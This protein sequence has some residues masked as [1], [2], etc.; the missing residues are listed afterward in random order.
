MKEG[1][2]FRNA[3]IRHYILCFIFLTLPGYSFSS[4]PTTSPEVVLSEVLYHSPLS[5]LP[6]GGERGEFIEIYNPSCSVIDLA[7]YR[8]Q[9]NNGN[10]DAYILS[11]EIAPGQYKT[12]TNDRN[13]FVKLFGR[14]PDMDN[15]SVKLG[16]SGDFVA[17]YHN[18][19]SVDLVS[20]EKAKPGWDLTAKN[21]SLIR[22]SITGSTIPTDWVVYSG[23]NIAY[24]TP[25]TGNLP[26][27]HCD[28]ATEEE[29]LHLE[30]SNVNKTIWINNE[31]KFSFT[32]T[33]TTSK[34][35]VISAKIHCENINPEECS[36]PSVIASALSQPNV[37]T[38]VN[39]DYPHGIKAKPG[40]YKF[41]IVARTRSGEEIQEEQLITLSEDYYSN[42]K[43]KTGTE[44]H[45]ALNSIITNQVVFSYKAVWDQLK[46]ID[47]D[48]DNTSNIIVQYA[49]ESVPKPY[50]IGGEGKNDPYAW[51]REHTWPKSHGF[52]K[53]SMTAYTDLHH[54]RPSYRIIN[55]RRGN[56]DFDTVSSPV[57]TLKNN[58]VGKQAFEPADDAKGAVARMMMY[59]DVRYDGND[60][61]NVP[62]LMLV[63]QT[64]TA[65]DSPLMGKL[66]TLLQWHNDYPVSARE[67]ERN[68]RIYERQG[69]RNPFI[70]HPEFAQSI[71]GDRCLDVLKGRT[72]G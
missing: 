7:E 2:I 65:K 59:M 13:G 1:V 47:E 54:L 16:N 67:R 39:L 28:D 4:V 34:E 50:R 53:E 14:F 3:K 68:N 51:N 22:K 27:P 64:E 18:N 43:G 36:G 24:G 69:N 21:T 41:S 66:C 52:K 38:V 29:D 62:N 44:L 31:G 6:A 37:P 56:L 46:Y 48:T 42:A 45:E 17:L 8:I 33:V 40:K 57:I 23:G 20:W 60:V 9:D 11:G 32:F 35:A 30:V 26:R 55:E 49:G 25:G 19:K 12:I 63:D 61:S 10:K 70:D 72:A 71:Y 58:K 15:M 5:S